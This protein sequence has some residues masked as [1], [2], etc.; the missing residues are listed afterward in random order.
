MSRNVFNNEKKYRYYNIRKNLAKYYLK[1][2]KRSSIVF[3]SNF[4]F[5]ERLLTA[6]ITKIFIKLIFIIKYFFI[7]F[8]KEFI[9]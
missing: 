9:I 3:I 4:T 7:M 6:L 1:N 8:I 2:K 5:N